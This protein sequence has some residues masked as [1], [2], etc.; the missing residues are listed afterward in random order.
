MFIPLLLLKKCIAL[1]LSFLNYQI[2]TWWKTK[3]SYSTDDAN[4]KLRAVS[5]LQWWVDKESRELQSP[6]W[7]GSISSRKGAIRKNTQR[8]NIIQFSGKSIWS[9]SL[10]KDNIFHNV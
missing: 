3:Q 10:Y 6:V 4:V 1:E 2:N 7:T 9:Q 5:Y 8:K